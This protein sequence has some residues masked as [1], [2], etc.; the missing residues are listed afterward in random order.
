MVDTTALNYGTGKNAKLPR[1]IAGKTGT[2]SDYK[3]AWFIGFVPQMY[4]NMGRKRRQRPNEPSHWR[5]GSSINVEIIYE[6]ALPCP[7]KNLNA[8][9]ISKVG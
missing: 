6:K 9:K 2:T 4:V 1:P 5:M 8:K 3:D 7:L